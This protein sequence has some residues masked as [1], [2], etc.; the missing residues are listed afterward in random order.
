MNRSILAVALLAV[1]AGSGVAVTPTDA[2]AQATC[3]TKCN[4]EEQAC[5][6]R[7]GNKGQCGDRA[8]QCTD[9]CK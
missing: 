5:L 2:V 8:K 3:R 4:E 1:I 9:K 7:T 6:Q